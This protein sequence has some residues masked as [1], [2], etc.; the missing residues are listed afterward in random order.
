MSA[1]TFDLGFLSSVGFDATLGLVLDSVSVDE[2]IGHLDPDDRHHQPYGLIH[3]GVYCSIVESLGSVGAAA[4]AM[5][6]GVDGAV[7]LSNSTD[8]LRFH[9]EGRLDARGTPIHQGRTQQLWLVEITRASD[10]KPVAR[11]QLRIYNLASGEAI[12]GT[13]A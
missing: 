10:G 13:G 9:R 5:D 8:F 11:G 1:M 2:T 7:G 4:Y 12:G 6:Q 3:G